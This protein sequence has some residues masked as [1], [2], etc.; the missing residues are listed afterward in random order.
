MTSQTL[1]PRNYTHLIDCYSI[2]R[3]VPHDGMMLV[4][5][6]ESDRKPRPGKS[7][8]FHETGCSETGFLELGPRQVCSIESAAKNNPDLDIFVLFASPRLISIDILSKEIWHLK[9]TYKNIFL[10]NNDIWKYAENTSAA[11][12]LESDKL[13]KSKYFPVHMSDLLRLISIWRF[14]GIYMDTDIIV[15]K[16]LQT[17]P[18]NY[19]GIEEKGVDL[20]NGIIALA[21]N[22]SGHEIGDMFVREFAE[23][24]DPHGWA[25]NGPQLITRVLKKL[26]NVTD[27]KKIPVERFK[28]FPREVFWAVSYRNATDFFDPKKIKG[29]D[30][31]TK[32]SYVIHVF[33]H[34]TKD[35][36]SKIGSKSLYD[37]MSKEHCP[38][39]YANAG[40][41]L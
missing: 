13:L 33:N 34:I 38:V 19:A 29:L 18:L 12:F 14:G 7:I 2:E 41:Y 27:L 31:Q 35:T 11:G 37:V 1:M 39:T 10:R 30:N 21:P 3:P 16:T 9:L 23:T 20:N 5:V 25:T 26:C 28:I 32:N 40:S 17:L 4:D 8:F 6:L 24:Y 36:K 15:K 22:G